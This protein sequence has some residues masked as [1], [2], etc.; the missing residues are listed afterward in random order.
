MSLSIYIEYDSALEPRLDGFLGKQRSASCNFIV[1]LAGAKPFYTDDDDDNEDDDDDDGE[2]VDGLETDDVEQAYKT[3][4][5]NQEDQTDEDESYVTGDEEQDDENG[6]A[7][8]EA[9]QEEEAE[10]IASLAKLTESSYVEVAAE[11]ELMFIVI[12]TNEA[13]L[14]A[15]MKL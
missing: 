8:A 1:T 9:D 15:Q 14:S 11:N 12:S 4:E 5:D 10:S 7:G 6:E 3:G 13:L 2:R